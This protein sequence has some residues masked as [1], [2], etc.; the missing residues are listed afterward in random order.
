MVQLESISVP[1]L[2][3]V[4]TVSNIVLD[5]PYSVKEEEKKGLVLK[6]YLN[7]LYIPIYQW[8]PPNLPYGLGVMEGRLD[9]NFCMSSDPYTQHRAL[10]IHKPSIAMSGA[11][12]CKVATIHNEV[13]FTSSMVVYLP[14]KAI[15]LTQHH[16]SHNLLNISCLVDRCFPKPEIKIG[17]ASHRYGEEAFDGVEFRK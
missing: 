4:G 12:T 10:A 15:T 9:L 7:S 2:V 17:V 5:C 3:E 1:P 6:W 8:M 14:P 13:S 11:Y 16:L